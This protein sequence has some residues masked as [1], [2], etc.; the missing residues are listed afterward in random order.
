MF[1]NL[2]KPV[3]NAKLKLRNFELWISGP[4]GAYPGAI[5]EMASDG[6][7]ITHLQAAVVLATDIPEKGL[8]YRS[9]ECNCWYTSAGAAE[10]QVDVSY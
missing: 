3:R 8:W 10:N 5:L 9:L 2:Q 7:A 1:Q 4:V 6:L